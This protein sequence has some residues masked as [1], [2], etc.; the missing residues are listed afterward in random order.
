MAGNSKINETPHR[1]MLN[2]L[3]VSRYQQ[4][5][6]QVGGTFLAVQAAA[7]RPGGASVRPIDYALG[8]AFV[9]L[10]ICPCWIR[11]SRYPTLFWNIRFWP[12]DSREAT[13]RME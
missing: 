7:T 2:L 10:P 3:V 11:R 6:R 1:S 8:W 4:R 5:A 13:V 12:P 9:Q